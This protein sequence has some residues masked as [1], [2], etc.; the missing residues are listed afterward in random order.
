MNRNQKFNNDDEMTDDEKKVSDKAANEFT[1][2]LK[3]LQADRTNQSQDF[4]ERL[5]NY[6]PASPVKKK[7]T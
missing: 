4:E 3:A 5:T 6:V 2:H 1:A 7:K